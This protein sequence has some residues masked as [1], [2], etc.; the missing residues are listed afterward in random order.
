MLFKLKCKF[1]TRLHPV[2]IST[3]AAVQYISS[4]LKNKGMLMGRS[5]T[6]RNS[7]AQDVPGER[8]GLLGKDNLLSRLIV[9]NVFKNAAVLC[10]SKGRLLCVR[11]VV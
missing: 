4:V 7:R 6:S 5:E 3:G 11:S 1:E 9:P 8:L 2:P 10:L